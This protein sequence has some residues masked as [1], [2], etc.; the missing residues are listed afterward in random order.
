MAAAAFT[1]FVSVAPFGNALV[2]GG[3]VEV[4]PV[5]DSIDAG[6][7]DPR[8][9]SKAGGSELLISGR[10]LIDWQSQLMINVAG[11]VVVTSRIFARDPPNKVYHCLSV[12]PAIARCAV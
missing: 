12:D 2:S 4:V 10:G 8:V 11:A 1:V 9:G 6:L 5:V 7:D 3:T